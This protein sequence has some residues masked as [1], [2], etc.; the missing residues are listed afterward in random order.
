MVTLGKKIVKYRVPILVVCLLLM[1]PSVLGMLHTRINY[2]MLD[3]L[4]GNMDTVQ[5]QHILLEDFGK[6]GFSLVT[7]SYTHLIL[8]PHR[9]VEHI[10]GIQLDAG[11]V[12]INLHRAAGKGFPQPGGQARGI[13]HE[14]VVVA[15]AQA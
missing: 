1:I 15:P 5:G 7:V 3:Y 9:A 13:Q 8:A 11:Q 6:G 10:A 12:G 14:V 2:D 4:P